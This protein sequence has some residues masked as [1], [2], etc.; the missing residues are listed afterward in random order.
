MESVLSRSITMNLGFRAS[1][2]LTSTRVGQPAS[3]RP[4]AHFSNSQ[5]RKASL[6]DYVAIR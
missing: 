3:E 6:P 4:K 1:D 5:K 2:V